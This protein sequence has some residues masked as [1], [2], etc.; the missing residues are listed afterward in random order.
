MP[1]IFTLAHARGYSMVSRQY[2]WTT[3]ALPL[4][5]FFVALSWPELR[6]SRYLR[7]LAVAAAI[8][9][10]A[11]NVYATFSQRPLRN[12][13]RELALLDKDSPLMA[14]LR[15]ERPWGLAYPAGMESIERDN[16]RLIAEWI[17]VRYAARPAGTKVILVRDVNGQ[18]RAEPM[19]EKPDGRVSAIIEIPR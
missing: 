9:I 6:P 8:L 7:V 18:L 19:P 4:A 14:L 12:D 5:L 17:P 16:L 2:I 11:G 3:T 1:L 10:V 13:S 15:T